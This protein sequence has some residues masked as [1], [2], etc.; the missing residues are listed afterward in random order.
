VDKLLRDVD[1]ACAEY[2]DV[3][4]RALACHRIQCDEVWSFVG[5]KQK[6][7]PKELKGTFGYGDAYTWIAIDADT[8]LVPCWHVGIRGAEFAREF[9]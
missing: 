5:I 1:T 8:K 3:H 2:Q 4:L 9:I 6:N 7:V